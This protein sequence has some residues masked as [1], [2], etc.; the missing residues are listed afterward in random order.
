MKDLYK[1][2]EISKL[3]HI[4]TDSLRYYEELGILTPTRGENGYR[5]YRTSDL[6]RLNVIRDMRE[7]GF[8]MMQIK[9]YLSH[10]SI[11]STEKFLQ[12]ELSAINDKIAQYTA[13]KENVESRIATLKQSKCQK[14]GVVQQID[15]PVRNCYAIHSG[16][17]TDEQMDMLIKRLLNRAPH[18]LYIIGNNRIGSV[19]PLDEIQHGNYQ[20]YQSVFIIDPSG[21]E[22]VEAGTYLTISYHGTNKNNEIYIPM[23][24]AEA[25]RRNLEPVDSVLELLWVDIHQ[26][27]N[28]EEHVT[29]LQ[30][31]CREV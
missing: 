20:K 27:E 16:Y 6:W 17:Q 4:G 12:D 31:W 25:K 29:E 22:I 1:I 10:R 13:L 30:M 24:L 19:I 15:F 11:D 3:Y 21:D 18:D 28:P 14:I 7:L 5:L 9:E 2:G 8:S 26:A 23:L